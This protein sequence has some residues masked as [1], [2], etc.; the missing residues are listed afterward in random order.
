MATIKLV[1]I[2]TDVFP[3][4]NVTNNFTK[5]VFWVKEPDS[6]QYPQHWEVELHND[7]AKRL[8]GYAAGDPVEVEVEVRGRQYTRQG[9][10]CIFTSL[11]C[12]GLRK[13]TNTKAT[14]PFKQ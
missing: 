13:L 8:Q 11:K 5:R 1:G 2:V 6:N 12:V 10:R 4:Q 3:T 14:S 9:S 7:E